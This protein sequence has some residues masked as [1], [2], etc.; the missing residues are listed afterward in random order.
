MWHIV[1]SLRYVPKHLCVIQSYFPYK[2]FF[3][4]V[5]HFLSIASNCHSH[6]TVLLDG[7]KCNIGKFVSN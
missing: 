1:Y 6:V 3:T 5:L 4:M 7:M 2:T